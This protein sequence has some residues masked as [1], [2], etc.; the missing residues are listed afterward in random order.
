MKKLGYIL[1]IVIYLICAVP[2]NASD[3]TDDISVMSGCS[4]LDAQMPILGNQLIDDNMKSAVLYDV[5]SDTLMYA[6][7][8]DEKLPP[9]SLLK[10][11][12]AL[13][14]IEKGTLSDAVTVQESVLATLDEDAAKVKLEIDEVV[15]VKDLIY[16]MMVASGNDAAVVLA[17]HVLGSQ[18]AFV[19]EMNRYAADLGCANTHFTNVHG[20][21]DE[22]QYTTARD[23]A[24]ILA[25]AIE[26]EEFCA[27]FGARYYT[28]PE[29]NKSAERKL[30]SQNYLLNN[31]QD[32]NYFDERVTGS[33][34]AIAND[35]S[36]GVA[37]VAEVN[38]RKLICIVMGADSK[39]EE[40]GYTVRVY[41]GYNET[42]KLLDLAFNGYK[43]A[44]LLFPNQVVIQKPVLNGSSDVSIGTR[45]GALSVIPENMAENG[46]TYRYVNEVPL[47]AP[48]EKGQRVSTLQIWCGNICVAQKDL[49]ALNSVKLSDVITETNEYNKSA[50]GVF[51]TVLLVVGILIGFVLLVLIVLFFLRIS[52]IA[53]IKR[54]RRRNSAYRRRS[55]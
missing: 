39:Y 45:D 18:Q 17:D 43:T 51:K 5:N 6:Y 40:D 19:E 54:H 26:N 13:I 21:H 11:L 24:R 15:T 42:K 4:T 30:S 44:Q 37:S 35:R 12:T 33:R 3:S 7:N 28:V 31:D 48:I 47:S 53:K 22:D 32:V 1:L 27:S 8:A 16:C 52:H 41:G 46:L 29:T 23:V 10:I 36:R 25:K 55:R 9:S 14:A 2:V 50:T 49:Y 38:D 20:L 34:T